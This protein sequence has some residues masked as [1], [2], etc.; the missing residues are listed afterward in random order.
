MVS[1]KKQRN[2][3]GSMYFPP[4]SPSTA[5]SPRSSSPK[6]SAAAGAGST[7]PSP[8]GWGPPNS[9]ANAA[10][11]TRALTPNKQ[12]SELLRSI[13]P[14]YCFHPAVE[15]LML[16]M[17]SQFV[18]DV[19]DFSG[20]IAKHRRSTVLESKDLQFCLAKNYGISLAGVLPTRLASGAADNSDASTQGVL[21]PL[22]KDLLVRTRPVKNSL[23]MHRM[24]LK[25]K[26]MQRTKNK[27]KSAKLAKA[28]EPGSARK[29][30]RK[31][32]SSAA[33]TSAK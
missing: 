29:L 15:E 18:E 13:E 1:D 16:E 30:M 9:F 8:T 33:D 28:G 32:S 3:P 22:G 31:A 17:A 24:A 5:S 23:H 21:N 14:R 25:R 2:A 27:L 19:V 11:M 6:G 12:L 20:K 26:N 4:M 10:T 7:Q